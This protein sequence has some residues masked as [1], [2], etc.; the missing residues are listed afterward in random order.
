MNQYYF[1][2]FLSQCVKMCT[3]TLNPHSHNILFTREMNKTTLTYEHKTINKN[4]I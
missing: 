2:S 4:E 1:Y 3:T